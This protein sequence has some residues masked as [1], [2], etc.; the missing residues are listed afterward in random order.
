VT[1]V[2]PAAI[3]RCI[4]RKCPP[5]PII[6]T[7]MNQAELAEPIDLS[8]MSQEIAEIQYPQWKNEEVQP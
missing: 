5:F 8:E 7:W 2:S 1:P 3:M 6:S 4:I